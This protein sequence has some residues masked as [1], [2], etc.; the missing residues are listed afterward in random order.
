M[1]FD[2]RVEVNIKP[3]TRTLEDIIKGCQRKQWKKREP[4][5]YWRGNPHVSP[6]RGDLMQCKPSLMHDWHARLYTQVI[7]FG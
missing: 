7:I 5:A 1:V 6:N 4:Y 2:D 3:W